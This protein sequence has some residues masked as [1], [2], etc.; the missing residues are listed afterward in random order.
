MQG[1]RA[2]REGTSANGRKHLLAGILRCGTCGRR[3]ESCWANSR[4]AYRCRHGHSTATRPD[5][6]RPKNLY[7]RQDRIVAY[8][9]ALHAML[10]G[11]SDPAGPAGRRRRRTRRGTAVLPRISEADVISYVRARQTTLTYDPQAQTLQA[12]NPHAVKIFIGP[13]S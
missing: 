6:A 5:P 12:D 3:L 10:A 9:P 4:P 11:T 1:I 7:I 2:A 8:L 13:A